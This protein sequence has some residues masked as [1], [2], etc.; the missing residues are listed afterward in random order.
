M[1]AR[2]KLVNSTPALP[3]SFEERIS[4]VRLWILPLVVL[5]ASFAVKLLAASFRSPKLRTVAH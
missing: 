3:L 2:E 5:A 4:Q 1:M